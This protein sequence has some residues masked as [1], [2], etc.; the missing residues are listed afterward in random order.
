VTWLKVT[1]KKES[2]N[3]WPSAQPQWAREEEG[4]G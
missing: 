4:E 2:T 3:K 1:P